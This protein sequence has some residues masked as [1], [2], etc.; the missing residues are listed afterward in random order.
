MKLPK[1]AYLY[2]DGDNDAQYLV[3]STNVDDKDEG[4]VGVYELRETLNVRH[5]AELR[6][7]GT[8]KWFK[9]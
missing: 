1:I 2:V 8:K 9:H 5:V 4:V 6:R 7:P 3:A